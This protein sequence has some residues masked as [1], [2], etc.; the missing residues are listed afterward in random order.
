M[1]GV[2]L[3]SIQQILAYCAT[4]ILILPSAHHLVAKNDGLN[5]IYLLLLSFLITYAAMPILIAVS[6][7]LRLVDHPNE[8]RKQH[9][10]PTPVIGGLAIYVSFIITILM[11]FH[12]SEE[13]KA[14]VIASSFILFLGLADDIWG[15]S[16]NIRLVGQA[17]ASLYIILF[18][19][20]MTFVPAYLGGIYTEIVLT[21]V[22]LIGITNSMN[23][24]DGMDGVASGSCIIYSAFFAVIAFVTK[25]NYFLFMSL[26]I[27]GSCFGFF[28]FNFRKNRPALVFLGDSGATFLGFLLA[29]FAILGEW[30]ESIIDIVIPVLIMSVLIFDM[31]LTTVVR[32]FSGEVRS[33]SQWL[34]YTGRD[35][36][37]HRLA[38]LGL[39]KYQATWL[40]FGVS[41]SFG[42]EA[43]AI[44]FANVLV[45]VLILIHSILVFAI[46]GIILVMRNK[47]KSHA[48]VP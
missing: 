28:I 22:W 41:I 48:N 6:D 31:T 39:S 13:L 37:H 15:L 32:I 23:F 44:L 38:D 8:A 19:V 21:L 36:F 40:F 29:S 24:I 5:S 17:A 30:G 9:A 3:F 18:G 14:I 11:N 2:K 46:I 33:F 34:H 35:H 47:N 26:A 25:Q 12:F 42:V 10:N 45:S 7:K 4:V 27:I 43:L 1:V 16:A 20:H